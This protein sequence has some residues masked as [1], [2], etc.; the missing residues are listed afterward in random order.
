VRDTS[1]G[2]F[3]SWLDGPLKPDLPQCSRERLEQ[4]V[5]RYLEADE[6]HANKLTI[7]EGLLY[8]WNGHLF[9]TE[10]SF[11]ASPASR[12]EEWIFVWSLD[13]QFYAHRKVT[14]QIPRFQHT[15]FLGGE[16]V[17][18]AGKLVVQHGVLLELAPHSGHYRPGQRSLMNLLRFLERNG[19]RLTEVRVDVQRVLQLNPRQMPSGEPKV[20]KVFTAQF[21]PASR[22]LYLLEQQL[23]RKSKAASDDGWHTSAQESRTSTPPRSGPLRR[24]TDFT[25]SCTDS[26][27]L[28]Q[29]STS[30]SIKIFDKRSERSISHPDLCG[31][32]G[33]TD[34]GGSTS[35]QSA[36]SG[37]ETVKPDLAQE[38]CRRMQDPAITPGLDLFDDYD[39]LA[40]SASIAETTLATSPRSPRS[41]SSCSGVNE[42]LGM[43][44]PMPSQPVSRRHANDD[45]CDFSDDDAVLEL[46]CGPDSPPSTSGRMVSCSGEDV[47]HHTPHGEEEIL[48]LTTGVGSAPE[49]SDAWSIR[50]SISRESA[51]KR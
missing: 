11:A 36:T 40:H 31:S 9:E 12:R 23:M 43:V 30:E 33:N 38:A 34:C 26:T 19:V 18:A 49:F 10:N 32:D 8:D 2:S 4:D 5:V 41:N 28:R 21:L 51:T 45:V 14:K 44:L 7:Q 15:S 39:P 25:A 3:W 20:A 16:P 37:A 17:Q 1:T 46:E 13:D 47:S 35:P 48:F 24:K 22:T 50:K 42:Q 29:R 6:R 27:M